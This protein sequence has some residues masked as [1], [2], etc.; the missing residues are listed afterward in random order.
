MLTIQL[1]E[2]VI[3]F[4]FMLLYPGEQF[5]LNINRSPSRMFLV[6]CSCSI[7]QVIDPILGVSI[8]NTRLGLLT[9]HMLGNTQTG[10]LD[11][12]LDIRQNLFGRTSLTRLD[13]SL[14]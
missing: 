11:L 5:N 14:L 8:F 1:Q 7:Y 13:I 10:Q 4:T 3:N 12:V 6:Q 2:R 9:L